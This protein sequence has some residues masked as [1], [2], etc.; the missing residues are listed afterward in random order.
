[1]E[2]VVA[3]LYQL[4]RDNGGYTQSIK[5]K[6]LRSKAVVTKAYAEEVNADPTRG[7][8]Y[9]INEELTALYQQKKK[10]PELDANGDVVKK[11]SAPKK[12]VA[13]AKPETE[14]KPED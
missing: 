7:K 4:G 8:Y 13:E 2:H 3:K 5:A 1:M 11:K 9:E 12:K 14:V 10:L 6:L